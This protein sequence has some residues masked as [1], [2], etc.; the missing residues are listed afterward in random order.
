MKL[1]DIAPD[2]ERTES[3]CDGGVPRWFAYRDR[4]YLD[5]ASKPDALGVVPFHEVRVL[6]GTK[7]ETVCKADFAVRW[8]VKSMGPEFQ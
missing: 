3:R 1:Q 5:M 4:T 8:T 6:R 2:A 7:P